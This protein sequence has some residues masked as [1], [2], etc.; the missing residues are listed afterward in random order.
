MSPLGLGVK[1]PKIRRTI[2]ETAAKLITGDREREHG[3]A[4]ENF[5]LVAAYWSA[6]LNIKITATDVPTMMELFKIARRKSG[7]YHQ[8]NYVDAAGYAAL[9]YE[10]ACETKKK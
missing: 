8:D 6:H 7:L 3:D 10:I 5:E 4:L 9:S 2:L 1:L